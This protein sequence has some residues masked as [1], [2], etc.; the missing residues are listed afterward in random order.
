MI[1]D[2]FKAL[3]SNS[4]TAALWS[5]YH[6]IICLVK[7][8]IR[9]ERLHDFDLHLATVAN[10]LPIFAA[11]G[12]GQYAKGLRLYLELM[13]SHEV[14][15]PAVMKTFKVVGL[16]TVRY[17][18]HEWSGVWTDLSIEQ[19]FMK[20]SKMPGGLKGGRMRCQNSASKMWPIAFNQ[21]AKINESIDSTISSWSSRRVE[22]NHRRLHSILISR[23]LLFR[24]RLRS[25]ISFLIG[26]RRTPTSKNP[27]TKRNWC[28]TYQD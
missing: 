9:S 19:R 7:D 5:T 14:Q 21:M 22:V 6:K 4:R 11:A 3:T 18:D 12:R 10:M 8:F 28:P 1:K 26:L 24:K 20:A 23:N 17:T 15:Y 2:K 16:H 27:T 25:L 13:A